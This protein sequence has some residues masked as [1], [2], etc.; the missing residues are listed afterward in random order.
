M[1]FDKLDKYKLILASASPRRMELLTAAGFRF[2]LETGLQTDESYPDSLEGEDIP[3]F[4]ARKKSDAF[5]RPLKEDEILITADT[6][7]YQ[8]GE[9][10]PK[11]ESDREARKILLKISGNSHFVFTGVC[12]RSAQHMVDFVASTEVRFGIL[13][14]KEI[15]YYIQNYKPYDKAGAYG[16][17]EWIGYVGVE[18][19][20]GSYFNVMG[21]PVHLL[22]RELEKFI[23]NNNKNE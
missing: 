15:N 8:N 13:S 9:V 21:M 22:Y 12:L 18:Q 3:L 20:I 19:I 7:V 2:E 14:E 11:P 10:L 5:P 17:Q 23:I 6:I 16:I 4:I 1:L